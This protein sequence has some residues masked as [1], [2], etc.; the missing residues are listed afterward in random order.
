MGTCNRPVKFGLKIPNCLEKMSENLRGIFL[1][2]TVVV[3]CSVALSVN[4]LRANKK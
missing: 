4:S 3:F 2:H 1:T